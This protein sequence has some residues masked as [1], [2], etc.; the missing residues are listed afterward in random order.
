M[1]HLNL[2]LTNICPTPLVVMSFLLL[3]IGGI[4]RPV[5]SEA[6]TFILDKRKSTV[7]FVCDKGMIPVEGRFR[8]VDGVV[9]VDGIPPKQSR[10]Q[11]TIRSASLT[12]GLALLD[13]Q[14]KGPEF[15]NVAAYPT[16]TFKGR[17]KFNKAGS[18]AKIHGKL[19][20]RSVTKQ[21]A[22]PAHY[23]PIK[24]NTPSSNASGGPKHVLSARFDIRRSEFG[25][26][27]WELMVANECQIRITAALK[28]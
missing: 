28:K 26:S 5:A 15:F 9:H 17:S 18:K 23:R 1:P 8:D 13:S 14:L 16:I 25:M 24:K 22:F 19:S 2:N 4:T 11:V 6:D 7:M 20:I 10:I 21:I 27:G 3:A 12:T